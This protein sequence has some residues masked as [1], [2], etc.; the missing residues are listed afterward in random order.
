VS[1]ANNYDEW[2]FHRETSLWSACVAA[3]IFSSDDVGILDL[4][5]LKIFVE[6]AENIVELYRKLNNDKT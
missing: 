1:I 6:K 5:K 3:Q 2:I 4:E